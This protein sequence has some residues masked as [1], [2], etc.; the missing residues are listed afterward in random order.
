MSVATG[1]RTDPEV[2]DVVAKVS[3]LKF[4]QVPPRAQDLD[5]L[6]RWQLKKTTPFSPDEA[7]LACQAGIRTPD[8]QEFLNMRIAYARKTKG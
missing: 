2:P 8:G 5:Q 3:I 6:I 4:A 7:Q 1:A